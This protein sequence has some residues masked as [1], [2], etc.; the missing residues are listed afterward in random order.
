MSLLKPDPTFYPSPKMAMQAPPER[1]AYVALI[2][3]TKQG[4]TKQGRSDAIGVVEG[5]G[6]KRGF[7]QR[8]GDLDYEK[9]AHTFLGDYR[10]GVLG[11]ISL[12]MPDT[13]KVRLEAHEA[14][15][16]KKAAE[17]AAIAEEKARAAANG[18]RGT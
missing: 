5:V 10:S 15:M 7:R 4:P 11:R 17:K 2:N 8:G 3:P 18:K 12:E 6:I 9:A 14:E 16:A 1:L 13:R